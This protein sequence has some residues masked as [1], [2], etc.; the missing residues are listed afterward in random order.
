MF[1]F[2]TPRA[3]AQSSHDLGVLLMSPAWSQSTSL[4]C[5]TSTNATHRRRTTCCASSSDG[6][7]AQWAHQMDCLA[8]IGGE[9][10]GIVFHGL[11]KSAACF[12]LEAGCSVPETQS[13]TGQSIQMVEHY[14]SMINRK[15]MAAGAML[16]WENSQASR[17]HRD[18]GLQNSALEQMRTQPKSLILL[19]GARRLELRTR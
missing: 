11:Q 6:F 9:F 10:D 3:S 18:R 8:L 13:I 2:P 17:T 12:L 14:G 15:K 5:A 19:V 4:P 1:D 7:L 16:R